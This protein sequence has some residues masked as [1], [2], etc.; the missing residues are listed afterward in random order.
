MSVCAFCGRQ[1]KLGDHFLAHRFQ[2]RKVETVKVCGDCE[3]NA[4][5]AGFTLA[6]RE[7]SS[8]FGAWEDQGTT[9]P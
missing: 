3:S 1:H 6:Q 9:P 7:P 5:N 2:P 4:R 8:P